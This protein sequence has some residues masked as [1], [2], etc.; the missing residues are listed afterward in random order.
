MFRQYAVV[1]LKKD[2]LSNN[3]EGEAVQLRSGQKGEIVEIYRRPG[4]PIG[5]EVEFVNDKTETVA[6]VTVQASD[7]EPVSVPLQTG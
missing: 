5:Y 4:F 7:I 2:I 6:L 3:F 1:K